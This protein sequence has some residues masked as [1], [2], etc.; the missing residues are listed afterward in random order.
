M[1]KE[2]IR[3]IPSCNIK[4]KEIEKVKTFKLWNGIN[5]AAAKAKC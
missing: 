2:L 5:A 4:I 3:S 1:I